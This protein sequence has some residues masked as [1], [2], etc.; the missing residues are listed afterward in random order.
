MVVADRSQR[1]RKSACGGSLW[2]HRHPEIRWSRLPTRAAMSDPC[3]YGPITSRRV[4]PAQA[5]KLVCETAS[6]GWAGLGSTRRIAPLHACSSKNLRRFSTSGKL[7][8]SHILPCGGDVCRFL[9]EVAR[10]RVGKQSTCCGSRGVLTCACCCCGALASDARLG[11]HR[12]QRAYIPLF[13]PRGSEASIGVG[14]YWRIG[15]R[16]IVAK[17]Q[18]A[19][20]YRGSAWFSCLSPSAYLRVRGH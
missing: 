11:R 6:A 10:G 4:L 14:K 12:T 17:S 7:G 9:T 8:T 18:P 3:R 5:C 16:G 19:D 1:K 2:N 13:K 20:E 15:R